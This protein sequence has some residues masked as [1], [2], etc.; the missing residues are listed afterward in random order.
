LSLVLCQ[1]NGEE[2]I[3]DDWADES[4]AFGA[5]CCFLKGG[6]IH[7]GP[8]EVDKVMA[9]CDLLQLDFLTKDVQA[10]GSSTAPSVWTFD[11]AASV[12]SGTL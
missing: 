8:V 2:P 7:V 1:S 10:E 5:I 6:A 11:D 12:A 3:D 4:V 9:I